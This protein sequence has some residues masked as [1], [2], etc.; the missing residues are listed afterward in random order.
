[1][2]YGVVDVESKEL[3]VNG[4]A[5]ELL[6]PGLSWK[7]QLQKPTAVVGGQ[8]QSYVVRGTV[9]NTGSQ[10]MRDVSF[11]VR[12][13]QVGSPNDSTRLYSLKNL[14]VGETREWEVKISL[15]NYVRDGATSVPQ[16]AMTVVDYEL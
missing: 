13:R 2:V 16:V 3:L 12:M 10:P 14:A 8:R 15:H 5:W 9:T 7:Y 11:A 6:P 1:V 4:V